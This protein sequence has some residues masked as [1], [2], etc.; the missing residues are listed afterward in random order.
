[1]YTASQSTAGY[2]M[3]IQRLGERNGFPTA[4]VLDEHNGDAVLGYML[5]VRCRGG[6]VGM[7]RTQQP[8]RLVAHEDTRDCKKL[9][10]LRV[11]S[12]FLPL[13]QASQQLHAIII[14]RTCRNYR[15]IKL[16]KMHA[17]CDAC[18]MPC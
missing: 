12:V 16:T 17:L 1:M 5:T 3:A 9:G 4:K 18:G 6:P 2:A 10:A 7:I 15:R 8:S 13:F 14:G 11:S